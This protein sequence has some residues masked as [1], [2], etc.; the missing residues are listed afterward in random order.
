ML[1]ESE[2]HRR[3][4]PGRELGQHLGRSLDSVRGAVQS[5]RR[6]LL[7]EDGRVFDC[8]RGAGLRRIEGAAVIASAETNVQRARRAAGAGLKKLSTVERDKL[9]HGERVGLDTKA[10]VLALMR[11][12][13]KAASVQKIE[14]AVAAT[15]QQLPLGKTL[16]ALR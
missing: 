1:F 11:T 16:E 2:R 10:T 3:G 5:A 13:G 15:A 9:T 6:V 14:K 8:E 7:N 4:K 12:A